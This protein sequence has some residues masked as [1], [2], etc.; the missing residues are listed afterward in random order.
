[1][2]V[3][4]GVAD[5]VVCYRAF[6]ERSGNRFGNMSGRVG[7]AAAVARRGTGRTGS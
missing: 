5:V 2:A 6:N 7:D 3:A 4:T 1:M